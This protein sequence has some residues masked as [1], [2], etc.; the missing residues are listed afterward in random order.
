MRRE[1]GGSLVGTGIT[2]TSKLSI[3]LGDDHRMFSDGFSALLSTLRDGYEVE[4]FSDPVDFLK[5]FKLANGYDLIVLDLVMRSMN[6]LAVLAAIRERKSGTPVMMLSGIGA[7]PPVTEMK[8][9]GARGFVHK[10][11]DTS[12]LLAGVDA[13]LAG[14][15]W[16]EGVDDSRAAADGEPGEVWHS[17]AE[18]ELPRLGPRQFE[19]LDL[20]GRGETKKVIAAQL[21]ISENTVK[22]HM[23]SIFTAL[24]ARTR[25]AC[26]RKAQALGLI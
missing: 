8:K 18:R 12:A 3:A 7:E 2:M 5:G 19:I 14:R 11:A 15:T 4:V 22:S 6:G 24:D 9:L 10:S 13:V 17:T 26:M 20:M 1:F 23:R 21:N 16:F 25:T